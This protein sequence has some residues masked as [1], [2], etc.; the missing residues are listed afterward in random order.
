L[1]LRQSL[2]TQ[3]F[4][5]LVA[6]GNASFDDSKDIA[7]RGLRMHHRNQHDK[8]RLVAVITISMLVGLFAGGRRA[9]AQSMDDPSAYAA[10]SSP[11]VRAIPPGAGSPAID[12]PDA[13]VVSDDAMSAESIDDSTARPVSDNSAVPNAPSGSAMVSDE[14]S[15]PGSADGA[16]LEIPQVVNLPGGSNADQSSDG[17]LASD[18]STD[19]DSAQFSQDGQDAPGDHDLAAT[20]DQ[21][22][23]LQDYQNQAEAAPLGPFFF[24]PGMAIVRFPRP[25]LF[26]TLPRPPFGVPMARSPIILPPTSNGPFPSTS[27]MLMAPRFG[28]LG[29][30]RS[31]GLMGAHR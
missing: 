15:R 20:A 12:T 26:N 24:A 8:I 23:T 22:G 17:G 3:S 6:I 13:P 14:A 30:F 10:D 1:S 5:W 7:D 19:D 25:P 27:P 28:T 29:S 18:D 21:L 4:A 9:H 31:G 2:V 16:V 11:D